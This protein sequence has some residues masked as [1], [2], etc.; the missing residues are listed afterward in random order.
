M[1]KLLLLL[2]IFIG[3]F[4]Y[5]QTTF[6]QTYVDRCTGDV[7]VVVANFVNGSAT[8]AFYDKV[9]TFTY[10]EFLSGELQQWLTET[11]LWWQALSPCSTAT[12]ETQQAQQTAQNAQQAAQT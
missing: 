1:R 8:V 5:G 6:T 12:A 9:R 3:S 10:Q 11:Y 7:R 2:F 4:T